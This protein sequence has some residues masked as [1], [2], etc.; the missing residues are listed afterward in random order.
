MEQELCR[1]RVDD[2][3]L[4]LDELNENMS[5]SLYKLGSMRDARVVLQFAG[6]CGTNCSL[7]RRS[8]HVLKLRGCTTVEEKASRNVKTTKRICTLAGPTP[9]CV[10][11]LRT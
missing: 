10:Q 3:I 2:L 7:M 6:S 8:S 1:G 9:L 11:H 4:I 5:V